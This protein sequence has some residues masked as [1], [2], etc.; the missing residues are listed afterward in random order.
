MTV[1]DTR[2]AGA[3]SQWDESSIRMW[4]WGHSGKLA[5]S[6]WKRSAQSVSVLA[7]YV[8]K[9]QLYILHYYVKL[10]LSEEKLSFLTVIALGTSEP[11]MILTVLALS[12]WRP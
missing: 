2:W 6:Q 11:S 4:R 8:V 9:T 7:M 10:Y 3:R 1:R 5:V 12:I